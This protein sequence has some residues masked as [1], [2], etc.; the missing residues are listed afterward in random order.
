M[1]QLPGERAPKKALRLIDIFISSPG[2]VKEERQ[3]ASRVI[4]SFNRTLSIANHYVLKPRA[5]EDWTPPVASEDPQTTVNRYM[6]KAGQS[7]MPSLCWLLS[8][9]VLKNEDRTTFFDWSRLQLSEGLCIY[10]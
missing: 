1:T 2:D 5:Y 8:T 6:M 3:I 7:E 10:F 9:S 4:E